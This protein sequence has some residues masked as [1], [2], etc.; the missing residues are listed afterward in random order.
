MKNLI[1]LF[2]FLFIASAHLHAARVDTLSIRSKSMKKEIRCVVVTPDSYSKDKKDFPVVYLLHGYSDNYA[3]WVKKGKVANLA[4]LHQVMIVCPDGG[5]DSWYWDS[6]VDKNFKYETHIIKEVIPF[7][8]K[9]Y[10]T[11]AKR[12]GRAIT[13]LSMGGQG[14][15][16]LAL[17]HQDMFGACGSQSG[18]V[19]IRPFPK[20]WGM[21]NRLGKYSENPD[22]W[23]KQTVINMVHLLEPNSIKIAFECG[24]D[25]FFFEANK[26]LHEKLDYYN[27]PHDFTVRPGKHNW[28]YW[29]NS[30]KYQLLFFSDY[31][32]EK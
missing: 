17:R 29:Q 19:D 8:D 9:N 5:Y 10:R 22:V 32:L 15:M 23:E 3:A 11:L 1:A 20:N 12:E 14:A 21:S 16:Y 13:G 6:P 4:D 18:G 30:V 25:D 27:I 7:V 2:L 31:F 28:N 24:K 26:K